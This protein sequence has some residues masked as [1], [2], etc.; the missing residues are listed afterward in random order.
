MAKEDPADN[1]GASATGDRD[2]GDDSPL[3]C[4]GSFK[5]YDKDG[6]SYTI[7]IWT[8]FD[9]VH[10]RERARVEPSLLVL[11]TT[12]GRGID[13]IEQGEY[14]LT[15]NPEIRLSSKDAHAP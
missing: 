11:R 5:A 4:I 13:H 15:D 7:E 3:Q 2:R 9:A 1:P 6:G 10:D 12:D 8:H 14:Q